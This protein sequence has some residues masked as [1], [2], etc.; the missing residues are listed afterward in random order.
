MEKNIYDTRTRRLAA[1]CESPAAG[2]FHSLAVN[3]SDAIF[4][5]NPQGLIIFANR[6]AHSLFA[7]GVGELRGRPVSDL[8]PEQLRERHHRGLARY[9]AT[10]TSHRMDQVVDLGAVRKDGT[11]FVVEL[12]LCAWVAD[13]G[14]YF[15]AIVRDRAAKKETGSGTLSAGDALQTVLGATDQATLLADLNGRIE[16]GNASAAILLGYDR[17]EELI[18]RDLYDFFLIGDHRR[19]SSHLRASEQNARAVDELYHLVGKE[20][21]LPSAK[22]CVISAA[23]ERGRAQAFVLVI[24]DDAE[25]RD[26]RLRIDRA[27][28]KLQ[29]TIR[30]TVRALAS[31]V[32]IRDPYTYGHQERVAGLAHAIA[33]EMGLPVD[34]AEGIRVAGT[35]HDIGKIYIPEEILNRPGDLKD[36]EYRVMPAHAQAG[37]DIVKDIEF[38]W[39]VARSI[40]QHHERVDGSGYPQ[41]IS[42]KSILLEAR[43]LA[44]ADVVEAMCSDRPYRRGLG[45][46][47][48]L[49]EVE[50][51]AGTMF[52][53]QVVEVCVKLFREKAYTCDCP[54]DKPA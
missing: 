45:L 53:R 31:T 40:L 27:T 5:V 14:T 21:D 18:G 36:F 44:V 6:A 35:I 54:V 15:G 29:R 22:V 52:D 37:H 8:M 4:L 30:G 42:G 38:D 33:I 25:L 3:A 19:L 34:R 26:M 51:N 41:G 43:I 39:P 17:V 46:D 50:A 20:A 10:R 32:E 11:E 13:D 16:K 47:A 23:D 49:S 1:D 7:Y 12:S 9:M 2:A 28:E 24:K 48:A